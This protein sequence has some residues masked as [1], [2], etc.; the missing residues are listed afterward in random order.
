MKI[1][2]VSPHVE[3]ELL[4]GPRHGCMH[5]EI[6]LK[7][8]A[9]VDGQTYRAVQLIPVEYLENDGYVEHVFSNLER[10]IG[11]AVVRGE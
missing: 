11:R 3:I 9:R 10:H 2:K 6:A 8:T 7:L 1:P 5:S 4:P